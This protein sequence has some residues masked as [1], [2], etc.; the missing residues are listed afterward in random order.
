LLLTFQMNQLHPMDPVDQDCLEFLEFLMDLK[1][2]ERHL[3]Q[4]TLDPL[5]DQVDR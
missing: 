4:E 5:L 3:D 2:L 1:V